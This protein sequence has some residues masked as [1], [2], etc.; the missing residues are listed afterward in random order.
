MELRDLVGPFTGRVRTYLKHAG[1]N[2]LASGFAEL[3][4]KNPP[5]EV[6]PAAPVAEV[7]LED[8]EELELEV[9]LLA[10]EIPEDFPGRVD[11]EAEGIDSLEAVPTELADLVAIA[12]IG[13]A[14]AR[15][16]LKALRAGS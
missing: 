8:E 15:R 11:L 2:A 5:P 9:E 3:P 7:E 14:T 16:I 4:E 6:V 1:E 13:K 10:T 12:G